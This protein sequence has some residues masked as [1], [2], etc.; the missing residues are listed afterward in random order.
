MSKISDKNIAEGVYKAVK[1][2]TG[3][4]LESVLASTFLLLAKK[5][6]LKRSEVVID[7]LHEIINKENKVIDAKLY[8]AVKLTP[9][10]IKEIVDAL[11]TRYGAETVNVSEFIDESLIGGIKITVGDEVL[12]LTFKKKVAQLKKHLLN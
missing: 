3:A 7:A 4:E 11:K 10:N 9:E 2:K 5:G 8:S 12:D 6:L 1:G